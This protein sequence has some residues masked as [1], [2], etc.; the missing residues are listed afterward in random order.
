MPTLPAAS[1]TLAGIAEWSQPMFDSMKPYAYMAA[2][3]LI[4]VGIILFV[5]YIGSMILHHM[6]GH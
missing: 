4:G 1:S 6:R 3:V 5:I 2:G